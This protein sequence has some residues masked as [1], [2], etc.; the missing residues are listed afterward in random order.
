MSPQSHF[1]PGASGDAR[2]GYRAT[3]ASHRRAEGT[4]LD[5]QHGARE[6]QLVLERF[7]EQD[8]KNI[9][10]QELIRLQNLQRAWRQERYE[11][12]REAW[13]DLGNKQ[14][15]IQRKKHEIMQMLSANRISLLAGETGSGKSTQ[16]A[17]YALEMSYDRVVYLQPRR[18][19]TDNIA[20]RIEYELR[21]QFTAKGI[22]YPDSL[23][24]AM[25][26]ERSTATPDSVV[27]VMT[28]AVYKKRAAELEEEWADQ[29]VLIVADEVHE[30]NIE[31]EFAI[32]TA[33]EQMEHQLGWNMVLMSATLNEDEIQDAYSGLNGSAIP[34]VTVEGRPHYIEQ[35]ERAHQT[36]TGVFAGECLPDGHRTVI[37]TDGK[38]SLNAI[39][40]EL[41]RQ[42]GE[43][44]EVLLLHSKVDSTTRQRIFHEQ[45]TPGVHQVI[46]STSA[47][48]S[49]IT[50]PGVD[51][52][53]SDGWTKSPEL[54][55]ENASGLPRRRCS[56]AELTQQMG[57][58]GRDVGGAKFFLAK[59]H[60]YQKRPGALEDEF[61]PFSSPERGDHIPPDIYHTVITNNVLS[62]AAMDKDFYRLNEYLIHK[63]TYDTIEEAYTIL[64]LLGATD[65]HN[66]V[67]DIGRRM[68]RLPVRPELARAIVDS[69]E[70]DI[71]TQ[72]QTIAIAAGIE[73]GGLASFS[74]YKQSHDRLSTH[75]DDDFISQLDLFLAARRHLNQ[76][77]TDE[78]KIERD[79]IDAIDSIRAHKQF[80]K[81]CARLGIDEEARQD[82]T[83]TMTAAQRR[84]LRGL[85]LSGMP[86]LLYEEVSRKKLRGRKKIDSQTRQKRPQAVEVSYRN[87]LA[88]PKKEPYHLDRALGRSSVL[89]AHPPAEGSY[90]AGYPRWFEDDHGTRHNV[91][92]EGFP[93]SKA[94]IKDVLS[95]RALRV[96]DDVEVKRN[97]RLA[98]I[99]TGT[100]GRLATYQSEQ[101]T[102]AESPD[103]I[104]QLVEHALEHPGPAQREL[105]AIKEQFEEYK[106]RVPPQHR[107]W[108]F[109]QSFG[110]TEFEQI[111][112]D[113]AERVGSAGQLDARIREM[114]LSL[115]SFVTPENR[116][117]V[118][119]NYPR[120]VTIGD[121]TYEIRYQVG[122]QWQPYIVIEQ[123][124]VFPEAEIDR[125]SKLAGGRELLARVRHDSSQLR[126]LSEFVGE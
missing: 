18:V 30:A 58:G 14:L 120:T 118:D 123:D 125:T 7:R 105:R 10:R 80:H 40:D 17:Q 88:P 50:I 72:L 92:Q 117:K 98:R 100:I 93:V 85:F 12:G 70:H 6:K 76:G 20:D 87:I 59:A 99:R 27:Q 54:D 4:G 73:S 71:Q 102:E 115:D 63:V 121:T 89:A 42:H 113:A 107:S 48:Q 119:Q 31:T 79:G 55:D 26:S 32:A 13:S 34:S 39:R 53:I 41:E 122:E 69:Q 108:Y 101:K 111:I 52:V 8:S 103:V 45:P 78:T 43:A 23:V 65:E 56:R 29:K 82:L 124:T 61:A 112:H 19:T 38:R 37:F 96:R 24:G 2:P 66:V 67:T 46:V 33:A 109:E 90:V 106:T 5:Y 35:H 51:R 68:D 91:I 74:N 97:G 116:A 83:N 28:S 114:S 15:P 60:P 126:P 64:H 62:A 16:L 57:R 49:G 11:K 75:T 104:E 21:E 9:K 47:G 84:R 44:I 110:Q 77:E 36:V 1:R 94:L 81:M 25:H 3:P 22:E 86:H 95:S